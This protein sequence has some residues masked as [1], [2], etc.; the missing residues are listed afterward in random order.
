MTDT[1]APTPEYEFIA[2]LGNYHFKWPNGINIHIT[3][4]DNEAYGELDI[5]YQN[6][7]K[8]PRL[9]HKARH[10]LLSTTMASGLAKSLRQHSDTISALE[11][12]DMLTL[13]CAKTLEDFR[14][15][16]PVEKL[17]GKPES[18]SIDYMVAPI[19]Q[20]D[21]A[22][23]FYGPGESAKSL[24]ADL[25]AVMVS[26]NVNNLGW[27]VDLCGP[28]II[29][30]WEA[31]KSDHKKRIW[32]IKQGLGITDDSELISYRFCT[33]PLVYEL[34]LIQ[35]AIMQNGIVLPIIDSRMAA[36]TNSQ[37]ITYNATSYYNGLRQLKRTTL[38]ID[39]VNRSDWRND[40]TD[41]GPG[42]STVIWNRSRSQFE[43][44]K[45]QEPGLPYIDVM[46]IHR[47]SNEGPHIND[48]AMRIYFD[49][50]AKGDT[51]AIRFEVMNAIDNINLAK[52]M[53]LSDGVY[54][55]LATNGK[56]TL[57]EL[58]AITGKDKKSLNNELTRRE[59][60]GT[61]I[62]VGKSPTGEIY[63]GL[64]TEQGEFSG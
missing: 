16:E 23:T 27:K 8:N 5:F 49:K 55:A 1:I 9:L 12:K 61:A 43:I 4:L 11:W 40:K 26:Y 35:E 7:D 60:A 31:G 56:L 51:T 33:Q 29:F 24:L 28:S 63:W 57:Y 50:D 2:G 47:K 52:S 58:E 25:I 54:Q 18:M 13:V 6:G 19:L 59:K 48:Q 10:N 36:S 14:R 3:R 45:N 30:D 39:H 44:K 37:D 34:P 64:A 42:G 41:I 17:G 32:A 20:A 21:M 53:S 38:T 46:M 22:T 62:H 15:G